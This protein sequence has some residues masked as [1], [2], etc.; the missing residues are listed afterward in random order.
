MKMKKNGWTAALR[1]K[2]YVIAGALVVVAAIG[3][4][5]YYSNTQEKERQ[6]ME[7]E[8][9]QEMNQQPPEQQEVAVE[10]GT[11]DAAEASAFIPPKATEATER[12][13]VEKERTGKKAAEKTVKQVET[14]TES[15]TETQTEQTD[16]ADTAAEAEVLH[17]VPEDGI[18]WPM[19]GNVILNYSM[20]ATTYFPTLDQYKYNPAIVISGDVNSKVYSVA[21]GKVTKIE[22]DP[23]TG[24]TMTVEL[25]DGYEAVY[26]QLK[27]LN[28]EVGDYVEAGHVLGYVNEP[29]KYFSVEGSNL[30]FE[31]LKDGTPVDPVDYFES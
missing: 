20:D 6:Q 23:V 5:V 18:N 12:A 4:T 21:R 26:G 3:T 1:R 8:L 15:E 16:A 14:E 19:E 29:T 2:Q 25:G 31:L 30:Y 11:E 13:E 22:N 27:E 10:E 17:F 28:F 9:A 7:A 24:C